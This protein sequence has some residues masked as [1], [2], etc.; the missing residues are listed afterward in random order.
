MRRP[1]PDQVSYHLKVHRYLLPYSGE[2][3]RK[4]HRPPPMCGFMMLY[5]MLCNIRIRKPSFCSP[6]GRVRGRCPWSTGG[7]IR[8]DLREHTICDC[9][10]PFDSHSSED[11]TVP[12]RDP[13]VWWDPQSDIPERLRVVLATGPNSRFGSGSGS[14][15]EPDRC[16]GFSPK[17]RHFKSTI[18][19]PIK[20]LSSDRIVT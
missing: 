12:Y 14:N 17:T 18:F 2:L 20:Y 11:H 10:C 13:P 19:A 9:F 8:L 16:N 7:E 6:S 3:H 1:T 4:S 5:Y 15:P